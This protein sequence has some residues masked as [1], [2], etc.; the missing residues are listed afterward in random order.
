MK[1][2]LDKIKKECYNI[3]VMNKVLIKRLEN[4]YGVLIYG[5]L[6]YVYPTG[7]M[8]MEISIS[9]L[10]ITMMT[11]TFMSLAERWKRTCR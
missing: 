10:S 8:K 7:K 11:V 6:H 5:T 3:P 2:K 4:A 1:N 9:P